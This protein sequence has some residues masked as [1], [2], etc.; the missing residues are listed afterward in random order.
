LHQII[1]KTAPQNN[2]KISEKEKSIIKYKFSF[3]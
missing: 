3:W 2:F 1:A